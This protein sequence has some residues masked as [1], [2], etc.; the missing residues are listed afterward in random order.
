M[1]E[2]GCMYTPVFH[3]IP[4]SKVPEGGSVADQLPDHP[5]LNGQ[6]TMNVWGNI[7]PQH[8]TRRGRVVAGDCSTVSGVLLDEGTGCK[9]VWGVGAE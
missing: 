4:L 8:N 6:N 3:I 1:N 5:P 7:D 9:I 2:G